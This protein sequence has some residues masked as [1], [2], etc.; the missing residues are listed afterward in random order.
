MPAP[1]TN[2]MSQHSLASPINMK[3]TPPAE[4]KVHP[5]LRFHV[6]LTKTDLKQMPN[7]RSGVLHHHKNTRKTL[8]T[9]QHPLLPAAAKVHLSR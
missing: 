7:T 5:N 9:P 2:G 4:G 8:K 6:Y 1:A 3:P